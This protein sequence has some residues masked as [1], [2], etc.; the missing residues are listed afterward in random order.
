M[1]WENLANFQMVL[2]VDTK[3]DV[4][5]VDSFIG[6]VDRCFSIGFQMHL[7]NVYVNCK[8]FVFMLNILG[9]HEAKHFIM[10][11]FSF[12]ESDRMFASCGDGLSSCKVNQ[13]RANVYD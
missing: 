4:I 8:G 7:N 2:F 9:V 5:G 1:R 11:D 6:F 3:F 10:G 12:H 13:F